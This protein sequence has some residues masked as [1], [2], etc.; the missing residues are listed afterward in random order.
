MLIKKNILL[1]TTIFIF[2]GC[3][4]NW[5]EYYNNHEP[6]VDQ[7]MWEQISND[8]RFSMFVKYAVDAGVDSFFQNGNA[9]T[10][11]IPDNEAFV[12][13]SNDTI[14]MEILMKYHIIQTVVNIRNIGETRKMET[15]G[16]KYALLENNDQ[17]SYIDGVNITYSSPLYLNGRYYIINEVLFPK[18]TLYEYISAINPVLKNYIDEFDSV[19][20]NINESTPIGYNESGNTIYDSVF[21]HINIFD[22]LY[23]PIQNEFRNRAAT[24]IIFDNEQYNNALTEMALNLGDGFNSYE[25]IPKK[26]QYNVLLPELIDKR[27]FGEPL[28]YNDFELGYLKNISGDTVYMNAGNI[29]P[30]SR[31]VCSNG[32]SFKYNDFYVADSLYKG[33]LKVQGE[34]LIELIGAGVFGFKEGVKITGSNEPPSKEFAGSADN[35]SLINLELGIRYTDDMMLEFF[36]PDVLPQRYRL[37]WSANFRPSGVFEVYVNDELMGQIDLFNLRK[38]QVSVT[39]EFFVPV[40]GINKIDFWVENINT[41]GNV[42]IGLKYIDSGLGNFNGLSIDYISLVPMNE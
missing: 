5:D 14:E 27:I 3:Q 39:G 12:N 2:F 40:E 19:F 25:D 24:M 13:F 35:D 17:N 10:V 9:I 31:F 37:V 29:D 4:E 26:W 15:S 30:E 18:P 21:S 33:E 6:N 36:I 23:F 8:P 34:S 41:Y 16:G 28:H 22:S 7:N 42:K 20:L 11:F 32:I 38:T 1:F